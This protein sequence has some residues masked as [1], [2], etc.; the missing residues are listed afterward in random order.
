M[1]R[2]A[3]WFYGCAAMVALYASGARAQSCVVSSAL[4]NYGNV[5]VLSGAASSTTS[6]FT[7][8]CTGFAGAT[9]RLC[10]GVSYGQN[11]G[12][13]T[14][15]RILSGASNGL[16]HD[17]F[18]DPA[19]ASVWGAP[20]VLGLAVYPGQ[21]ETVDLTLNG[22]G[23]ATT[24]AIPIYGQIYAGQRTAAPGSYTWST[25]TPGA[26]YGYLS[27]ASCPTGT[28]S[29]VPGNFS[30]IWTANVPAKCNISATSLSFGSVGVLA[31]AVDAQTTLGAQCTN[32]TP[33]TIGL[34]AGNGSGATTASR[35]MTAA[36]GALVRYGLYR[37]AARSLVWG[38]NPGVDTQGGAGSGATQNYTV[39]G[40]IPAQTTPAPGVFSDTIIVTVTY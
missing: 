16:T 31:A 11:Y 28:K 8:S 22:A 26:Q 15:Q 23:S 30:S 29:A 14:T 7:V 37:D 10:L 1:T 24:P 33:Y 4:G 25:N 17:L 9:V 35:A 19:H 3:H 6:S 20:N 40:R 12:G 34:S 13:S 5:D 21:I 36:S 27:A 39:Y 32:S 18:I 38:E 2:N